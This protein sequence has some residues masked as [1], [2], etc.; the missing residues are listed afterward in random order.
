MGPSSVG[1]TSMTVS[2]LQNVQYVYYLAS[3]FLTP[4]PTKVTTIAREDQPSD[5]LG[6]ILTIV[7]HLAHKSE[8]VTVEDV[9]KCMIKAHE[10]QGGLTLLNSFN[11]IGL[12]YVILVK[13]VSTVVISQA[14]IHMHLHSNDQP[15]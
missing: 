1:S 11:H 15:D 10:I 5:N 8:H 4:T 7:D 13:V 12:D 14:P 3:V 6:A 2:L 9:L